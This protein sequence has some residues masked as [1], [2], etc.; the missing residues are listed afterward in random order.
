M[1]LFPLN[2]NTAFLSNVTSVTSN[3]NSYH[4]LIHLEPKV[5]FSEVTE[6]T[7]SSSS[8]RNHLANSNALFSGTRIPFLH[9]ARPFTFSKFNVRNHNLFCLKL[10]V[11]AACYFSMIDAKGSGLLRYCASPSKIALVTPTSLGYFTVNYLC[12]WFSSIDFF[13]L[14]SARNALSVFPMTGNTFLHLGVELQFCVYHKEHLKKISF[15]LLDYE[16]YFLILLIS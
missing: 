6:R 8:K 12:L 10:T 16:S 13:L 9:D 1:K 3:T 15:F 4:V 7:R 5:T 2:L 11:P 14:M